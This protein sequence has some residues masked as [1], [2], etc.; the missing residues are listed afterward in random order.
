MSHLDTCRECR[1]I[2]SAHIEA[3]IPIVRQLPLF[4]PGPS[5]S[6]WYVPGVPLNPAVGLTVDRRV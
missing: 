6:A 1:E 2:V 4:T 5:E 3:S